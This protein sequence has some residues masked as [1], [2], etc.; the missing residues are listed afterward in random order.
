MKKEKIG[1]ILLKIVVLVLVFAGA[2]VV[3]TRILN[4]EN[5]TTSEA[6]E[7]ATLPLVYIRMRRASM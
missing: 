6:M 1:R 3:S 7:N 5:G 4:Q 2:F